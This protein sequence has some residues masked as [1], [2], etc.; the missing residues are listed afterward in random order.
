MVQVE[1][2]QGVELFVHEACIYVLC[3]NSPIIEVSSDFKAC[4]IIMCLRKS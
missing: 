1:I 4:A 2:F 3:S